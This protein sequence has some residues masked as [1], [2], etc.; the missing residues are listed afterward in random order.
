MKKRWLL[1]IPLL[2][3]SCQPSWSSQPDSPNTNTPK[4]P[5]NNHFVL[6]GTLTE[7]GD[8]TRGAGIIEVTPN[9]VASKTASVAKNTLAEGT[10]EATGRF[11]LVLPKQVSE[12]YLVENAYATFGQTPQTQSAQALSNNACQNSVNAENSQQK[13]AIVN[14]N[15]KAPTKGLAL[16]YHQNAVQ[17]DTTF[18]VYADRAGVTKG[19][20]Q[21]DVKL[22]KHIDLTYRVDVDVNLELKAGWNVVSQNTSFAE[23]RSRMKT[24]VRVGEFP[25]TWQFM[26]SQLESSN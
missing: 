25:Q 20:I 19:T 5:N 4:S 7:K 21:C 18:L 16:S 13:L 8:W 6:T 1:I 15:V 3:A 9:T 2:L 24:I 10:I 14:L 23:D 22:S 17:S 12:Q 26:P 11:H